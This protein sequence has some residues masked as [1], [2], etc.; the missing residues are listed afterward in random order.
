MLDDGR[1]LGQGAEDMR[2]N[3]VLVLFRPTRI[4]FTQGTAIGAL[5]ERVL[6]DGVGQHLRG[7]LVR[8]GEVN[9]VPEIQEKDIRLLPVAHRWDVRRG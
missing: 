6:A 5:L 2:L 7:K 8:C 4:A 1:M 3:Q 9:L